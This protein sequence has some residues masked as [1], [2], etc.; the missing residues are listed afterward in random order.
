MFLG[1]GERDGSGMRRVVFVL[2]GCWLEVVK[3]PRRSTNVK[4]LSQDLSR[5][6]QKTDS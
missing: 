5:A 4:G 1:C 6:M 2:G 3:H